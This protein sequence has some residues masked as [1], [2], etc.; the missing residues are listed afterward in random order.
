MG[1]SATGIAQSKQDARTLA[2]EKLLALFEAESSP[3]RVNKAPAPRKE[4][5]K[6]ASTKKTA[7]TENPVKKAD[8]NS[9]PKR[10]PFQHKKHL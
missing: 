5:V 7:M 6:A 10:R 8:Q 9:S 2:A 4:K 1:K 3:K